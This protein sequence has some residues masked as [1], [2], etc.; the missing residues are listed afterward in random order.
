MQ[1]TGRW[2][3]KQ[4]KVAV[5]L[6]QVSLLQKKFRYCNTI[7]VGPNAIKG[8]FEL[9]RAAIDSQVTKP[10]G[11]SRG[12]TV[13]ETCFIC[14]EATDVGRMFSIEGCLHRYCFSCMKQHVEAKLRNGMVPK[15]PHEIVNLNLEL[16]AVENS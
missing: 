1:V 6:N 4:R 12:K 3:A 13:N 9:A 5:L 2:S 11:P 15:C 14:L 16:I 10:A 8:V 7:F